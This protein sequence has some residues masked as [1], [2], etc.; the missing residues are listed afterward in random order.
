MKPGALRLALEEAISVGI[1]QAILVGA[2][3]V[4]R[5]DERRSLG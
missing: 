2:H 4:K 1:E 3:A 5:D